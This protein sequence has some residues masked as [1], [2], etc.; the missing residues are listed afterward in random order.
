MSCRNSLYI[1]DT[2]M[3]TRS[4]ACRFCFVVTVSHTLHCCRP[5][6]SSPVSFCPAR[7]SRASQPWWSWRLARGVLP[8]PRPCLGVATVCLLCASLLAAERKEKRKGFYGFVGGN[9][10]SAV[11]T[12]MIAPLGFPQCLFPYGATRGTHMHLTGVAQDCCSDTY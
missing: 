7:R 10:P 1:L 11:C 4:V 12:R 5:L 3:L 2:R 9:S 8:A 6:L